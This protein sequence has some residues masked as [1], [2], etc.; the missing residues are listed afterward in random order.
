MNRTGMTDLKVKWQHYSPDLYHL[1]NSILM[2]EVYQFNFIA[3]WD[4]SDSDILG[5][6]LE[7]IQF[8]VSAAILNQCFMDI[9]SSGKMQELVP[10]GCNSY[11]N[12]FLLLRQWVEIVE[13]RYSA[14]VCSP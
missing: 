3:P 13:P 14:T 5:V 11:L 8:W 2:E 4:D 12:P 6:H 9:L 1:M 10:L 7:S